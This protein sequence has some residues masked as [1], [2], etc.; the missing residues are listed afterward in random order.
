MLPGSC[1][2]AGL[3]KGSTKQPAKRP[4]RCVRRLGRFGRRV[5]GE[6]RLLGQVLTNKLGRHRRVRIGNRQATACR[7][8][9]ELT[10]GLGILAKELKWTD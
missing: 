9:S 1:Y 7:R 8:L 3:L 4:A 6:R 5:Y 10:D 2:G